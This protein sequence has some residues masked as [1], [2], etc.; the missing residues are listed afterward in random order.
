MENKLEVE[1]DS[2]IDS[3]PDFPVTVTRSRISDV[4]NYFIINVLFY[5]LQPFSLSFFNKYKIDFSNLDC[6]I[7]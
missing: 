2:S 6:Q 3:F 7:L 5:G 4:C 1:S